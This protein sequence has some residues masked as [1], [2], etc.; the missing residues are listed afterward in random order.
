MKATNKIQQHIQFLFL[1]IVA[2]PAATLFFSSCE[3][4]TVYVEVPVE[5]PVEITNE[6]PIDTCNRPDEKND[7]VAFLHPLQGILF[8]AP[9]YLDIALSQLDAQPSSDGAFSMKGV[10]IFNEPIE[11]KFIVQEINQEEL[12]NVSNE[13]EFLTP[14]L[15]KEF[16]EK[17][18]TYRLFKNAKCGNV[19][20]GFTSQCEKNSDGTSYHTVYYD[21]RRCARGNEF[22]TEAKTVYGRKVVFLNDNCQGLIQK[23]ELI[24]Y[25]QCQ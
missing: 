12:F 10:N 6:V 16:T 5:V 19:S 4:E 2:I 23:E 17:G 21:T 1:V 22:C 15:V 3:K 20:P 9:E 13:L 24:Y 25:W 14:D 18:T 8:S 7:L 11:I